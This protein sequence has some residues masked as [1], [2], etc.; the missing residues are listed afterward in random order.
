M[1][2]IAQWHF[3]KEEKWPVELFKVEYFHYLYIIIKKKN[4]TNQMMILKKYPNEI[5]S[6]DVLLKR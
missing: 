2:K 6:Q 5:L 1:L 4:H 3:P